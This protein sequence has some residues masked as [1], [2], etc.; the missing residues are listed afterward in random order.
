MSTPDASA[1]QTFLWRA[2]V[3]GLLLMIIAALE[4]IQRQRQTGFEV[5]VV[6]VVAGLLYSLFISY[7]IRD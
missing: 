4:D 1:V 3:L 6:C 2:A 7:T 5:M